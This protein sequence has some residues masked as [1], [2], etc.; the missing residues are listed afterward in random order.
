MESGF[1]PCTL[2]VRRITRGVRLILLKYYYPPEIK[3]HFRTNICG[4]S[5]LVFVYLDLITIFSGMCVCVCVITLYA[6]C[7]YC[8]SVRTKRRYSRRRKITMDFSKISHFFSQCILS[9]LFVSQTMCRKST[10]S[11]AECKRRLREGRRKNRN[12][13]FAV[14]KRLRNRPGRTCNLKWA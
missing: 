4:G 1:S 2:Q 3:L 14:S 5:Y 8:S 13:H 9:I 7:Y 6:Y 11:Q 12:L 10:D